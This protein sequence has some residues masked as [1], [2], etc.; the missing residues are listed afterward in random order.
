MY[1][2]IA[3]CWATY[4]IFAR[5]VICGR[6]FR[7]NPQTGK[8]EQNVPFCDQPTGVGPSL[9]SIF[10]GVEAFFFGFFTICMLCDQYGVITA[11]ASQIDQ[12]KAKRDKRE[13]S[14][15]SWSE[16]FSHIFGG[17][18]KFSFWWLIPIDAKWKNPQKEFAFMLPRPHD[19]HPLHP[20]ESNKTEN[21]A[22]LDEIPSTPPPTEETS[23][24]NTRSEKSA[25]DAV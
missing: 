2:F 24:V 5:V 23:F 6:G 3:C 17:D 13:L 20:E 9:M 14:A 25:D 12:L 22:A 7:M 4:L 18:G 10:L 19:A 21:D 15:N 11:G 8:Y 16:S 1:V